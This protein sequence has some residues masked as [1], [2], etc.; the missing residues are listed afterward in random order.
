MTRAVLFAG[1]GSACRIAEALARRLLP[2]EVRVLVA[3]APAE[4]TDPRA[5]QVLAEV[6]IDA[7]GPR[8][9]ALVDAT[10]ATVDLVI[11]LGAGALEMPDRPHQRWPL[12]E[13]ALTDD[14]IPDALDRLRAVRDDLLA[15]VRR[16][17]VALQPEPA[18]GVIGGSGFYDL[19]GLTDLQRLDVDT[20]YGA[21]SGPLVVGRL[22]GRRVVF[23]AR[24]GD[25]HGLLPGEV[26]ARANLHAL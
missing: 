22:A 21:P 8:S 14:T 11:T 7:A 16:L 24:H 12:P 19:P 5:E 20:P 18:V 13:P 4:T 2:P 1:P 26:N 6:G 17:S 9:Q 25:G 23:L 15:R 10:F 3:S